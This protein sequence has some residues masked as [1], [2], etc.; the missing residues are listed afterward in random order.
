MQ[1]SGSFYALAIFCASALVRISLSQIGLV[2]THAMQK[3]VRRLVRK[4]VWCS[5]CTNRPTTTVHPTVSLSRSS[6]VPRPGS[7]PLYSRV[8]AFPKATTVPFMSEFVPYISILMSWLICDRN[9]VC[10]DDPAIYA[11]DSVPDVNH[12]PGRRS[13]HA[14]FRSFRCDSD[15]TE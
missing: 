3:R 15:P 8:F 2:V 5:S 7:P 10:I 13:T 9:P 4:T 6:N 1:L 14:I 11:R 12:Y